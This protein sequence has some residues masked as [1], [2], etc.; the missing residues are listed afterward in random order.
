MG[1]GTDTGA[2]CKSVRAK[3]HGLLG[4]A[5][6]DG[7]DSM[8]SV[9]IAIHLPR[10]VCRNL[11]AARQ[12]KKRVLLLRFELLRRRQ[13]WHAFHCAD[14]QLNCLFARSLRIT[15]IRSQQALHLVLK[16]ADHKSSC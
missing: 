2:A 5:G 13:E 1:A 12:H 16:M 9:R 7:L 3:E 6:R 15:A 4:L 10:A 8:R 14:L 11:F